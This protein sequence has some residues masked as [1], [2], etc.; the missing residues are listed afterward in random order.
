MVSFTGA[1]LGQKYKN[2]TRR[3]DAMRRKRNQ[4]TYDPS[5]SLSKKEATQ[6]LYTAREFVSELIA[7]IKGKNPQQE[8]F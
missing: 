3:F 8:L 2:L 5:Y 1:V 7:Y 4:F 6:S